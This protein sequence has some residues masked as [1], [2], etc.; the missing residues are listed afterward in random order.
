MDKFKHADNTSSFLKVFIEL[1]V[2]LSVYLSVSLSSAVLSPWLD[3]CVPAARH[4]AC[5]PPSLSFSPV[6]FC[7]FLSASFSLSLFSLCHCHRLCLS[8]PLLFFRISVYL[9]KMS[10]D[11]NTATVAGYKGLLFFKAVSMSPSPSLSNSVCFFRCLFLCLSVSLSV[12]LSP[13]LSL[14]H[15]CN[16]KFGCMKY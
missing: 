9:Y 7:V 1:C 6:L 11:N 8:H 10:Y 16:M 13:A 14:V 4:S 5:L 3:G 12:S 15:R 2:C